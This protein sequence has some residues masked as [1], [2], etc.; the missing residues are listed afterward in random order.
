MVLVT[1][2]T[3][4]LGSYI[5]KN[6][7]EKG[8]KVRA[9]RRSTR[10][11]FWIDASILNQ[12]D[13]IDADILDTA[14][15]DQAMQGVDGIIHAAAIVSF[16]R[17][18]RKSMYSVNVDGTANVVN[19]AIEHRIKRI[20]HVSSIA[21][22]GRTTKAELITEERKWEHNS[23]NT[24]YAI[25][26]HQA[27]M[28]VWRGFAEGLAGVIIN[29]STILGYGNWHQSSNTIFKNIYR[30]FRWYTKGVNGFVGV[31]DCAEAAVQLLFSDI[32]EQRFI[33]NADN[34]VFRDLFKA[35]AD[36]FGRKPPSREAGKTLGEIAWR[37][38]AIK[39]F[40]T[41]KKPL[42]TK[43]TAKVGQSK[44]SFDGTA[45]LRA[46]PLFQYTPLEIVIKNACE[47]YKEAVE[48]ALLSP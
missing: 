9:I 16:T 45:V 18:G 22:L 47:N 8:H 14:S 1:G 28:H 40:F 41:G 17:K 35:I 25:S 37:L 46:L 27:E 30:G 48:K 3:G 10:L 12:V 2:G 13:W 4:F 7:V 38:E 24:H 21:A 42:L 34:W 29:P 36:G 43:E 19:A 33:V 26:K 20:V 31:E 39:A 6:L 44:T 32:T 11:P 23:N 5:I 15:M